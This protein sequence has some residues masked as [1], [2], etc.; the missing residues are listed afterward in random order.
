MNKVKLLLNYYSGYDIIL[1]FIRQINLKPLKLCLGDRPIPRNII[2]YILNNGNSEL[3]I[4]LVHGKPLSEF[5]W[6]LGN[7]ALPY[8]IK[9]CK[10]DVSNELIRYLAYVLAK[11]RYL[12]NDNSN[13][14]LEI[15]RCNPNITSKQYSYLFKVAICKGDGFRSL[16]IKSL[17]NKKLRSIRLTNR[18]AIEIVLSLLSDDQLIDKLEFPLK[19]RWKKVSTHISLK[20]Y[21]YI[22]KGMPPSSTV[23]LNS[24]Y[25]MDEIYRITHMWMNMDNIVTITGGISKIVEGRILLNESTINSFTVHQK[26]NLFLLATNNDKYQYLSTKLLPS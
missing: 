25:N 5:T 10:W 6:Y 22:S 11:L 16:D 7:K 26:H 14:L 4:Y 1:T 8:I 12:Y 24:V 13:T 18:V 15:A 9:W 2:N 21:I 3:I 23:H 20:D 17:N 19:D